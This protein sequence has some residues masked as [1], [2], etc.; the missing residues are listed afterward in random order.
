MNINS[1]LDP[2]DLGILTLLQHNGRMTNKELAHRLNRAIS[3]IFER[4]KRLEDQGY[5]RKYVALL[6]IEKISS[7]LI[8]FPQ[9]VLTNHADDA[10]QS[11][12]KSIS[13][14]TEV[15]EC[16]HITGSYDFMLKIITPN[17]LKYN[18]FMRKKISTLPNVGHVHSALVISQVKAETWVPLQ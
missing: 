7:S 3:P 12:Q 16:Y 18:E 9:I 6:D 2:V 4:R 8:A 11:F 5:I 15:T 14:F 10:L 1:R 17:M 13:A